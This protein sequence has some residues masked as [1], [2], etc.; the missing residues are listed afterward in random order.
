MRALHLAELAFVVFAALAVHGFVRMAMRAE[1]RRLCAPLCAL[2]PAYAGVDRTAPDF[3]LP[4]LTGERVRLSDYRGRVVVLNFW[5]RSCQ[6]CRQELPSLAALADGAAAR[7]LAVVTVATDDEAEAVRE[8]LGALLGRP[9]P[10]VVAHDPEAAVVTGR[11][12]TR[13]YPETWIIDP[14]GVIRARFDG[15]RDWTDPMVAELLE[16]IREPQRCALAFAGGRPLH[17]PRWA[18]EGLSPVGDAP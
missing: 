11:Y 8:I 1:Q 2:A 5:T 17:G 13:L 16:G 15:A 3:D 7:G 6:P 18:C 9:P 12:G 4:T 10:F 14:R